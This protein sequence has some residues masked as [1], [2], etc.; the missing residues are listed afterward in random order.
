M[1]LLGLGLLLPELAELAYPLWD[2]PAIAAAT[3]RSVCW[4]LRVFGAEPE[5]W[6]DAYTIGLDGFYVQVA[7]QCSGVEGFAL[8]TGFA[9]I[10][11]FLFR[12]QV[13]FPHF[14]LV[15][16]PLGIVL[17]WLLNVVRIAA[18]IAIGAHVSPELAVNG[19]HSYA[20]WMFF[21]LLAM[22][23]LWGCRRPPGCRPPGLPGRRRGCGCA[24]IGRRR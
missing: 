5:I 13:R 24:R 2:W 15:V 11:G 6:P 9:L 23:M 3:F 20:G 8:V 22:A 19:F 4:V 21:T 10:Y 16:I 1:P 17:S 14:W 7:Q 12:G 18:L